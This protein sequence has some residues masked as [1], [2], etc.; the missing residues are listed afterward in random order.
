MRI[1]VRKI[2][3]NDIC[4]AAYDIDYKDYTIKDTESYI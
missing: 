1:D 3:P 4:K 2:L